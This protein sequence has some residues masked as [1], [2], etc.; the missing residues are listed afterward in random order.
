MASSLV[1]KPGVFANQGKTKPFILHSIRLFS[2]PLL[3]DQLGE[4]ARNSVERAQSL[5]CHDGR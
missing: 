4:F 5:F 2:S 3:T 1:R